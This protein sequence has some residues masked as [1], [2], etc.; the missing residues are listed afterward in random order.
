MN[1]NLKILITGTP[2]VGKTTLS[3]KISSYLNI[4]HID[5]SSYIKSNK[6]F[7]SYDEKLDTLVFDDKL[8]R[9]HLKKYI[10]SLESFIIDTHTPSVASGINFD[11][12]FHIVCDI[13][14]IGRRL[15]A[16]G[17]SEQKI[18][19]NIECEIFNMI[20]EELN[21]VFIS[22]IYKINGS[23]IE[24]DDAEYTIDDIFNILSI[25]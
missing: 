22:K 9:K 12:I 11:Y 4:E 21:D 13:S 7:E 10:K 16:R 18:N 14:E 2:G 24:N 20:G 23:D 25:K 1:K 5:V 17:Y 6:L 19:G 3:K 8:V 15:D